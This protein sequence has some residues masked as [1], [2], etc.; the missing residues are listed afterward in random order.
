MIREINKINDLINQEK[1]GPIFFV[2]PNPIYAVGIEKIIRDYYV[3][4]AQEYDII[5][6]LRKENIPVLSLNDNSIKNAGK[7][8]TNKKALEYIKRKSKKRKANIITFKPSP[9][10]QKACLDNDFN[11]LGN[12]WKLSAKLENKIEFIE[13]TK[14]LKIPNAECKIIKLD[15]NKDSLNFSGKH[16]FVLQLPRG[17]AGNSTFLIKNENDFKNL[18]EKYKNRTVKV[19]KYFKGET[20]TINAC[21]VGN[22]I[23]ISKPIFQITGFSLY[24]KNSFGGTCGNDYAYPKKLSRVQRKKIFDYTNKI[25]NYINKLGYRG[26]FG[27]D[28]VVSG[29]IVNLI[30][31]NPR[32]IGSM[33]LFTKLQIQ[34]KQ[35]PF[36][37]LSILEFINP[38]KIRSTSFEEWDKEDCFVASQLMLRNT[39][40]KSIEIIKSIQ[41]GIYEMKGNRLFYKEKVYSTERKLGVEEFLVQ[42]SS[43]GRLV[44]SDLEYANIQF[45][46]GIM[47][48]D[49]I[50]MEDEVIINKVLDS[51]KIK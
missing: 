49:N 37:L 48:N 42:C 27:L 20:Y 5:K 38:V 30:E 28:F 22:K 12:D 35:P 9:M 21:V 36:L 24:N 32:I 7:I 15:N 47:E 25:G 17:H 1:T 39:K 34:S 43:I 4:C 40:N 31:I 19:S 6:F 14:K 33:S 23:L 45:G 41:S 16:K 13:V 29:G 8:L 44:S 26:I 51:I 2:T 46:H 3:I 50:K 11:Y 10:I 18:S